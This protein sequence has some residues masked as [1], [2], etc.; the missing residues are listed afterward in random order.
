MS[1]IN[2]HIKISAIYTKESNIEVPNG[3]ILL[4]EQPPEVETELS[5]Q[6]SFTPIVFREEDSFE[7]NLSFQ[8]ECKYDNNYLYI[9][10][11]VQSGIFT[12]YDYEEKEQI[13]EALAVDCPNIIF[14]YARVHAHQISNQTGFSPVL[15]QEINFKELYYKEIDKK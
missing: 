4:Q 15:I 11:F 6:S 5:C 14:P 9:L 8:I 2:Q 12:L 1:T 13:E 10:N 3:S 7:V